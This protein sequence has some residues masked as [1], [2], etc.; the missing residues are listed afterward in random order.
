MATAKYKAKWLPK[1][2]V[3]DALFE[4]ETFSGIDFNMPIFQGT[5]FKNCLFEKSN[6]TGPRIYSCEFE[7]CKF[8]GMNLSGFMFGANNDKFTDCVFD[9]CN[10]K[11]GSFFA[12][13]FVR[14]SFLDC[15]LSGADLNGSYFED[16]R[17]TGKI[18]DLTFRS[19]Y[20][21]DLAK[22]KKKNLYVSIDFS[23][24]VFGDFVTFVDCDLSRSIP[25]KGRTFDELLHLLAPEIFGK[26]QLSTGDKDF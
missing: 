22:P 26:D 19:K 24:A 16:C 23:E 14:T 13:E 8:V 15:K 6:L 18:S 3:K 20:R 9:R 1:T 10:L 17:V 11:G 2:E 7:G 5:T 25:P 12:P 4:N 21:S